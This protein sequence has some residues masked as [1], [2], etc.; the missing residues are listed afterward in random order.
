[1]LA[2]EVAVGTLAGRVAVAT[3]VGGALVGVCGAAGV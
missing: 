1:M 2:G 3:L